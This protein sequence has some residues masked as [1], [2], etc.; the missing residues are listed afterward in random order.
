MRRRLVLS[1]LAAGVLATSSAIAAMS[2]LQERAYEVRAA[3]P[4]AIAYYYDHG[5]TWRGMTVATLKRYDRELK[6]IVIR[7]A[8]K[9]GFCILTTKRP[10]VHFN[11][12][13]GKVR[14]GLCGQRGAIV[15]YVPRPGAEPTPQTTAQQ[16]IRNAIPA[17]EAYNAD[18]GNRGYAGMTIAALRKYDASITGV[19]IVRAT[20]DTYCIESGTG[21]EQYH[22]NGPGAEITA[23]SCPAG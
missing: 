18:N 7:N 1:L 11:G 9:N 10:F 6:N 20:S 3:I 16:R 2:P 12:P 21:A 15:P 8:T 22:K 5:F 17:M 23:G 4:P 19:T 14:R 13:T